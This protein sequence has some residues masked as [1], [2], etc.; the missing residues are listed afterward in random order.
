MDMNRYAAWYHNL[1]LFGCS[2]TF[3]VSKSKMFKWSF[4]IFSEF[5]EFRESDKSLKHVLGS[6]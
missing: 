2:R 1:V 6:F 5:S 4:P 3:R